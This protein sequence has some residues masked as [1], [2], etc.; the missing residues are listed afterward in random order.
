MR[1]NIITWLPWLLSAITIYMTQLVGDKKASAWLVGLANQLL[2]VVYI[3]ATEAWGLIPLNIA[4]W[5][6]YTRNYIKWSKHES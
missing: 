6:A 4:L 3:L 2:W 5:V 1:Q